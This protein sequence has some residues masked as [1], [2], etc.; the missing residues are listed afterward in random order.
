MVDSL[1]SPSYGILKLNIDGASKGNPGRSGGGAILRNS[2]GQMVLAGSYFY[3]ICTN[4]EAE[5]RA[6]LNGISLMQEYGLQDY[7]L[8]IET[9]SKL[10]V[11]MVNKR[12]RF[13]GNFGVYLT[14]FTLFYRFLHLKSNIH[15]VKEIRLQ[16][17][18]Q[19]RGLQ[20]GDLVSMNLREIFQSILDYSCSRISETFNV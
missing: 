1:D 8:I 18:W 7:S 9:D 15:I 4:M 16:I 13:L 14:K 11:D 19:I 10:L 20:R 12:L 6:L 3:G 17:H 2:D 5:I